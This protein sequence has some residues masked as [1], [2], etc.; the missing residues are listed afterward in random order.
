MKLPLAYYTEP[1]LRKKTERVNQI[2]DKLRQFVADMIETMHAHHGSGLAAPQVHQSL[3][4][5]VSCVPFRKVGNEWVPGPDRVFINPEIIS[6]SDELQSFSEGCLSI[7][8]FNTVVRRPAKIQIRAT[9]L[10]GNIF[11]DTLE[12][13]PATNF[14]HEY[15]HLQGKL[16]ID[17]YSAE[18]RQALA[19]LLLESP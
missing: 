5:F 15:D 8:N 19:K 6:Q 18:Q 1:V 13:F 7:P 4:L 3:T 14:M 16:I 17:Y 12:G 10:E 11:E 2:D 9:D